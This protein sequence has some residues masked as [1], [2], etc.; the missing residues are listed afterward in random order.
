LN[1]RLFFICGILTLL[2]SVASAEDL[3]KW[4]VV[5][6][7]GPTLGSISQ[8]AEKLGTKWPQ[9][10]II[11]SGDCDGFT[12]GL[13]LVAVVAQTRKEAL[14]ASL[15][16][17]SENTDAYVRECRPRSD[18][19]VALG[20]PLVDSSIE[21]VPKDAVNWTDRD[22][23]STVVRLTGGGHLWFRRW[24]KPDRED[25]REGRRDSILFFTAQPD[26]AVQLESDCTDPSF[27]QRDEWLVLSCA[28]EVA[29]DNL[30][31]ETKVYELDSGK[32]IFS[33]ER[34]R[35]PEFISSTGLACQAE[36]VNKDGNLRLSAKQVRFR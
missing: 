12:R 16:L 30:F 17:K 13:Y 15:K 19:R 26:S 27:A 10:T 36:Q 28:R 18:S 4:L 14:D 34:C 7:S 5:A 33:T 3:S 1:R 11:A 23:I 31:H 6:D 8:A 9:A 20:V 2:T 21:K 29:A 35:N 32:A 25:P 22:R 24:Y